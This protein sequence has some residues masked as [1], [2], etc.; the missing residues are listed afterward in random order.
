MRTTLTH[1]R[2]TDARAG[3]IGAAVPFDAWPADAVGRV[4]Q[5]AR[6][7]TFSRGAVMLARGAPVESLVLLVSGAA[8]AGAT[9]RS[10]RR[11][12]FAL[13]EPGQV[14]GIIPLVDGGAMT[15]DIVAGEPSVALLLPVAAIRAELDRA[16]ALWKPLARELAKRSRGQIALITRKLL[17]SPRA[18]LAHHLLAL[19]DESGVVKDGAVVIR[20]R[21]TQERL[22]EMLA[23]SRQTATVLVREFVA[24]GLIDWRYG[25]AI[26]KDI[27]GLRRVAEQ[28]M[29]G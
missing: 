23:V 21:I 6:A 10:G 8:H 19:A 25:R 18:Q 27:D 5:A 15:N 16:P 9:G 17:D 22:G 2:T 28:G 4:A 7:R 26:L 29:A 12:T 24:D 13:E 14:Y 20:L 1:L 11:Q 3:L